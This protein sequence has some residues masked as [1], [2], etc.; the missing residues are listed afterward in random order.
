MENA[1]A[2]LPLTTRQRLPNQGYLSVC[3]SN[4][5]EDRKELGVKIEEAMEVLQHTF[6]SNEE[7]LR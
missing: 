6:R 7:Q 4:L 3:K 1:I 5:S 2:A